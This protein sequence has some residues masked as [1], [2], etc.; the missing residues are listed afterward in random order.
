MKILLTGAQGMVGKNIL[1]CSAASSYLWLTPN[2]QDL[3]L[4]DFAQT[5][6]WIQKYQPE[7][8]IHCAGRVGGIQA[9]IQYPVDFLVENLDM[10]RNLLLAAH[11]CGISKFINLASTCIYPRAS[12]Q[13]LKEDY[14]LHGELEPTNE[15]YALAK[16]VTLRLASYLNK[17]YQA[18]YKTLIPCN[19]FGRWDSFD[20]AR[21]H[22]IPA[23]VRKL[24]EAKASNS[25]QV[26]IWGDGEARREF[27]FASDLADFILFAVEKYEILPELLNVGLGHD[28]SI[29]E[30]YQIAA[31]VVGYKGSY[32][33]DISKPVGMKQ[34]LSDV[35]KLNSLGWM[36]PTS[37]ADGLAKTYNFF[38]EQ[39]RGSNAK[40]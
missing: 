22:L 32:L 40:N 11:H 4:R 15:G 10:G 33:H 7:M 17:Q 16:I 9:N 3:D 38:Q 29:N 39:N 14:I 36:A 5:K 27:M 31:Q 1:E 13:P 12:Q 37:L 25:D 21:S 8:I 30:Y 18:N 20:P 28:Y 35:T 34:K 6:N 23:I 19:L 2:R 24:H 26:V